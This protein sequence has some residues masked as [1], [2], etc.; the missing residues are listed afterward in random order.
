MAPALLEYF[1][2][3]GGRTG[4]TL[5]PYY[6]S[7]CK[8]FLLWKACS[9]IS[10]SPWLRAPAPA[11]YF[12]CANYREAVNTSHLSRMTMQNLECA[13]FF[14]TQQ[15]QGKQSGSFFSPCFTII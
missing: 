11:T 12:F 13:L 2:S 4:W 7:V 15:T 10:N 5:S 3:E 6:F 8:R 1:F 14:C 9:P